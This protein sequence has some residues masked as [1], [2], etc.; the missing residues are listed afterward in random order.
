MLHRTLRALWEALW[1]ETRVSV[2]LRGHSTQHR[3]FT[4]LTK[5]FGVAMVVDEARHKV[6][7]IFR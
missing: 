2:S 6:Q 5:L 7:R 1:T 4:A 3:E